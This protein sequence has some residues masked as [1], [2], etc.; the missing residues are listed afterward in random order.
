[1]PIPAHPVGAAATNYSLVAEI[2]QTQKRRATTRSYWQYYSMVISSKTGLKKNGRDGKERFTRD[3]GRMA[4]G[5]N[6]CHLASFSCS[7]TPFKRGRDDQ[8]STTFH[9]ASSIRNRSFS[10][11]MPTT[12]N[13]WLSLPFKRPCHRG[14]RPSMGE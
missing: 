12:K 9:R 4:V 13:A 7:G 3:K 2:C 1:M 6:P 11:K 5:L 10:D 8:I 14:F